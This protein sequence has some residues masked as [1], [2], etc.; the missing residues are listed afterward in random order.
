[1]DL[2]QCI[3]SCK[4]LIVGSGCSASCRYIKSIL[5]LNTDLGHSETFIETNDGLTGG[6]MLF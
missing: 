2:L 1:M 4:V 5:L 3:G 6:T